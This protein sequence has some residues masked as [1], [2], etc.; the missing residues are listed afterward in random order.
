Y[1]VK[2][3]GY[4]ALVLKSKGHVKLLSRNNNDL[5]QRFS[6]IAQ[7][8]EAL[9]D[10]TI[11]DGEIVALDEKGRPSFNRLQ[12]DREP[13]LYFAFDLLAFRGKSL[14]K[15]PRR[16]RRDLLINSALPGLF[17]PV[18]LSPTLGGDPGQLIAS[19]QEQKLEGLVAKNRDS[20][21]EPGQRSGA[22][23]KFKTHKGQELVVG[24]YMP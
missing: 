7:A 4:R 13:I 19:V 21:Y 24:G 15:L 2:L 1:E 11:V 18:R 14:V 23:V 17:D 20:I 12:N 3:D 9:E 5:T 6:K 16:D 22:W 10:N 8:F